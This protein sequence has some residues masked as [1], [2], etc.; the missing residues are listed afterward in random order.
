VVEAERVLA[1]ARRV[2][3]R[4]VP[5]HQLREAALRA[6]DALALRVDVDE[7][8]EDSR[9]LRRAVRAR[10]DMHELVA[11]ARRE[12]AAFF[13]DRAEAR[14]ADRP[15]LHV[16]RQHAAEPRFDPLP[17]RAQDRLDAPPGLWIGVESRHRVGLRVVA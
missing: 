17:V 15:A 9:A 1:V 7:E 10:V 16:I 4:V 11:R 8:A 3:Q 14:R 5:G 13:L 2:P 12:L 6:P